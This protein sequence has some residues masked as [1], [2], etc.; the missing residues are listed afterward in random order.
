MPTQTTT[1]TTTA[2]AAASIQTCNTPT[3]YE[4]PVQDAACAV[5]Y[6]DQYT[7]L[8]S[9]C[10]NNAPVSAYDN[11]CAIYCLAVGQSVQDLTDCLYDAKVDWGDV[12]C[13]G[14]T[15]ASAT[16]SPTGSGIGVKETGSATGKETGKGKATGSGTSTGGAVEE[17]GKSMA[18]VVTGREVSR[19][20]I[21]VVGWLVVSSVFGG[22]V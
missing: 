20:S 2:A 14:N 10:C 21:W 18:G 8:L 11:D 13:F 17:T 12:W 5:P 19:V 1:T 6:K 15:S 4:I 9:K 16:G 22:F 3:Q 7:K